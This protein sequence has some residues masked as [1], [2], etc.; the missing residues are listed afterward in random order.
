MKYRNKL[1]YKQVFQDETV[2]VSNISLITIAAI[3]LEV[4]VVDS[5]AGTTVW[6][7]RTAYYRRRCKPFVLFA[8]ETTDLIQNL[9]ATKNKM[10]L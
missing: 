4:D 2:S 6:K 1:K 8:E 10:Q 5:I 7:N 3:Q 9:N